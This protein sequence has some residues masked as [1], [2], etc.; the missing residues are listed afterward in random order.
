MVGNFQFA[1]TP[2]IVFGLDTFHN[3][4]SLMAGYG[5]RI[6]ILTGKHSFTGTQAWEKLKASLHANGVEYTHF[7]IDREPSPNLVDECVEKYR[8]FSPDAVLA[9]GGGSVLDA[10][11]AVSAM[12]K[13]EGSVSDYLEGVGTRTPGPQ[14]VPF[15]AVPTTA[16]TGSE[17]TKNAVISSVGKNGYKKSL[18]HNNYVPDIALVDPGLM[19][20]APLSVTASSGMDAFT[21]LLES[22]VSTQANPMTDALALDG[23]RMIRRSLIAVCENGNNLSARTDMAY[24]SL[25]SGI[26]LANA[27]LGVVHGFASPVGGFFDIPH[28]VVCGTLMGAAN[29]ISLPGLTAGDQHRQALQ[30]YGRVGRIFA[31]DGGKNSDEYYAEFLISLIEQWVEEL[32]IPRLGAYGISEDDIDR[33]ASKTGLKN[34]PVPLNKDELQEILRMRL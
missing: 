34:H 25:L 19:V 9:I 23:L 5:N 12:L 21:Q 3:I 29:R 4:H 30:K 26:T 8:D 31:D 33:I 27:G 28:G 15:V 11:K 24:A 13:H 32:A 10:G 16:G 1:P 7:V 20:S 17:A 14:K 22:Y 18:R 6:L 2:R